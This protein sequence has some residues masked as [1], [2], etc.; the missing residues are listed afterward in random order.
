MTDV[1]E[2]GAT[3]RRRPTRRA[4]RPGPATRRQGRAAAHR[5]GRRHPAAAGRRPHPDEGSGPS[6]ERPACHRPRPYRSPRGP[7]RCARPS[8]VASRASPSCSSNG[9][10]QWTTRSNVRPRPGWPTSTSPRSSAAGT[11]SCSPMFRSDL[12]VDSDHLHP[13]GDEASDALGRGSRTASMP[14]R[15]PAA[16]TPATSPTRCGPGRTASW[17][18]RITHR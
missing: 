8:A 16:P 11:G 6:P 14:M 4:S 3:C 15:L 18:L 5:V 1:T 17:D 9:P 2:P 12:D 13:A 10:A 7:E